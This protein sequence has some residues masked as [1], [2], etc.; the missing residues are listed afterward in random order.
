[1]AEP[2]EHVNAGG[3]QNQAQSV[4]RSASGLQ[5]QSYQMG[6][7]ATGAA[8]G[9]GRRVA[10]PPAA[11]FR[12]PPMSSSQFGSSNNARSSMDDEGI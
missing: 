11:Q 10:P 4:D 3:F 1:M 5:F 7:T 6:L 12:N 9:R 2:Q 8:L